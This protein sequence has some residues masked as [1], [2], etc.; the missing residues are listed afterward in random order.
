MIFSFHIGDRR[1][2]LRSDRRLGKGYEDIE[3]QIP[4]KERTPVAHELLQRI[5]Y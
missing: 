5:Q 4:G 2:G 1:Y 3:V